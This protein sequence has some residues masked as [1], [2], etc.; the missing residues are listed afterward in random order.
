MTDHEAMQIAYGEAKLAFDAGEY[1]V[2]A[3][4]VLNGE[5]VA[6]ARNRVNADTD[7]TAHA[8]VLVIREGYKKLGGRKIEDCSLYT[9]LFPCP[10]CEKTIVEVGIRRVVYGATSFRWIREHKYVNL[11]PEVTGPVME[12]E[13]RDIFIQRLKERNRTDI[14]SFEQIP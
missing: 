10:M 1:P 4:L 11:V 9:S 5:I 14:L 7:P 3:L 2:G 8:E 6:Q 13:C 12:R